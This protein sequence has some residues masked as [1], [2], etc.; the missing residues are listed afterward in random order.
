MKRE[1]ETI[2][3]KKG[4]TVAFDLPSLENTSFELDSFM[5]EDCNLSPTKPTKP[6][7]TTSL[8]Y[9]V[10]DTQ[11]QAIMAVNSDVKCF[12]PMSLNNTMMKNFVV[13]TNKESSD[14]EGDTPSKTVCITYNCGATVINNV[15]ETILHSL[16]RIFPSTKGSCFAF[17]K[18]AQNLKYY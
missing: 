18:H 12:S 5:D 17:V 11:S 2:E 3:G 13:K 4:K 14:S 16:L 9:D 10:Q 7:T 8:C 15:S 6:A 1:K